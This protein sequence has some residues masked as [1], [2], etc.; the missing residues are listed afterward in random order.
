M[1]YKWDDKCSYF[2]I[3]QNGN[4]DLQKNNGIWIKYGGPVSW[5]LIVCDVVGN[6]SSTNGSTNC[7]NTRNNNLNVKDG[8]TTLHPK[9]KWNDLCNW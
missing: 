5:K 1:L 6:C 3:N 7:H 9:S 8:A 4:T 2:N